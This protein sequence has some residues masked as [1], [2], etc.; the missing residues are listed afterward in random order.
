MRTRRSEEEGTS[1]TFSGSSGSKFQGDAPASS[2]GGCAGK[3]WMISG[4]CRRVLWNRVKA[5]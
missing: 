3:I 4:V 1:S 2:S 5:R